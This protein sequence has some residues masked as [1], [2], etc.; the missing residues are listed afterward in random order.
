[1]ASTFSVFIPQ[2]GNRARGC[3]A[4]ETFRLH[5]LFPINFE[6]RLANGIVC[7]RAFYDRLK[8][9]NRWAD[10]RANLQLEHPLSSS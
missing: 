9:A 2:S 7:Q 8:G 1:M 10:L 4:V 3:G 5:M 6:L